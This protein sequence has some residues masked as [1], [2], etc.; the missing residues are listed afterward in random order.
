[1]LTFEPSMQANASLKERVIWVLFMGTVFFLLYGAANEM[2]SLTGPH[3]SFYFE[4]EKSIDFIPIFIIPY[5]S[6]DLV[7]VIA[8]LLPQTRIELRTLALR[9]LF[10]ILLSVIVFILIPLEFAFEKPVTDQFSLLFKLLEADK[11]FNQL[12]SLHISFAIVFWASMKN[13][14]SNHIV[15]S[16]LLCWLLMIMLSTLFVYQHHFIDIPTGLAVGILAVCLIRKETKMSALTQ[17]MTPRHL[18]MA[19]YFLA[20]SIVLILLSFALSPVFLYFFICTFSVSVIYAF[21]YNH[22][23]DITYKKARLI[24]WIIFLPYFLGCK[25]SWMLYK[26]SLPLLSKVENNVYFGR[27]PSLPEYVTIKQLGVKQVINLATELPLNKTALIQ[28]RFSF[29]DQTIQCPEAIHKVVMLIEKHK[30]DGIYV[31][32]ALGLSRSVIVIWAWQLFN[33]KSHEEIR[34]HLNEIRPNYVQSKYMAVN[35]ALY[36]NFLKSKAKTC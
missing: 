23:L 28:H 27:H 12:P 9:V 4:W 29:L 21:G 2:A 35:I 16:V 20:L 24:R 25:I 32:C 26:P 3:P 15:K 19:Y 22:L 7:F 10:I 31:H 8:F 13:T 34:E 17:F 33:G 36:E 6:S 14:L 5:M 30:S 11:P 18:K 1:M